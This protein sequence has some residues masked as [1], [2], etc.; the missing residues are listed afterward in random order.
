MKDAI[1]NFKSFFWLIAIGYWVYLC[2]RAIYAPL[3]F[4]EATTFFTY[5]KSGEF[6]PGLAYWSANNHYLN[7]LLTYLAYNLGGMDEW[8]LRLPNLL[9]FPLF[10]WFTYRIIRGFLSTPVPWL[11]TLAIFGCH[12]LLEF[13]AYSRGYGLSL[14][15]MMGALFYLREFYIA[16]KTKY[17]PGFLLCLTLML[18]ANLS[19]LPLA[20]LLVVSM[21]LLLSGRRHSRQQLM[22]YSA[23]A[24]LPLTFGA[25]AI[26]SLRAE[27]QLYYGGENG[28]WTD[29]VRSLQLVFF[30]TQHWLLDLLFLSLALALV[31]GLWPTLKRIKR[32]QHNIY[33][34][35]PTFLFFSIFLFYPLAHYTLGIKFPFDRALLYWILL[36]F[37]AFGALAEVWWR[38]GRKYNWLL[39]LPLMVFPL[40]FPFK[41]SLNQSS[42]DNWSREQI[43]DRFYSTLANSKQNHTVGGSYLQGPQW[44]YLQVK[45]GAPVNTFQAGEGN[46]TDYRLAE[47]SQM[48][49]IPAAYCA[50]DSNASQNLFLL[51]RK[52]AL[53]KD[54]VWTKTLENLNEFDDGIPLFKNAH[55]PADS[56]LA[57]SFSGK[58][59][60][61][62]IPYGQTFAVQGRDA[63]GETIYWSAFGL[64][65]HLKNNC[66]WQ[67]FNLFVVLDKLPEEVT[68]LEI[69]LWNPEMQA[70][71]LKDAQYSAWRL[72]EN[73]KN[74]RN[75]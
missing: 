15:F 50:I 12:Y 62:T 19:A 45:M 75:A 35:W 28:F 11:L 23:L 72:S 46:F 3:V 33:L 66:N 39:L 9:A 32:L 29:S 6:I 36:G 71:S 65:Q 59:K 73:N 37:I 51:K 61:N 60:T 10:A 69:F 54:E 8:L 40:S 68:E 70:F 18:L 21:V 44:N 58:F 4:D 55:S 7:S 48:A 24:V 5:V 25:W 34:L 43:P 52:Q 64:S 56:N 2:L 47:K 53:R 49:K 42:T 13:F 17:L 63:A 30:N 26:F 74:K 41:V 22:L 67:D 27:G 57:F 16:K 14:T 31:A 20:G 38:M 1:K